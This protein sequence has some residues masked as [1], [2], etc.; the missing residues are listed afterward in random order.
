MFCSVSASGGDSD[1]S[2]GGIYCIFD[3]NAV[4]AAEKDA[5]VA[6]QLTPQVLLDSRVRECDL[7]QSQMLL[8]E[9]RPCWEAAQRK[10]SD[11]ILVLLELGNVLSQVQ[12]G[13]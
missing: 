10:F 5:Q 9:A 12:R 13:H 6:A 1:Y 11:N 4:Q 7:L 3:L 8:R 2:T